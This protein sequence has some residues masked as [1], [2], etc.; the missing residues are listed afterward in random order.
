MESVGRSLDR[1]DGLLADVVYILPNWIVLPSLQPWIIAENSKLDIQQVLRNIAE[2]IPKNI[3][4]VATG[5][6]SKNL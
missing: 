2:G 5:K 4:D 3:L 1:D 6:L